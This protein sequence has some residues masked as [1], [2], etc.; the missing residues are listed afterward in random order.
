MV[1]LDRV[2]PKIFKSHFMTE[3]DHQASR[4]VDQVMGAFFLVRRSVFEILGG[5]DERFFV[6]FEEVDLAVRARA[7][8][9]R[10]FYLSEAQAYHKGGG[11]THRIKSTSL[12]Y[13][14]RSRMLY[15][16]KHFG[17]WAGSGVTLGTLLLEPIAR[18][19]LAA[20][21]GP[22]EQFW[23]TLGAYTMLWSAMPRTLMTAWRLRES[24]AA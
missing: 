10:T 6:Y 12:F 16:Y 23:A 22:L 2:L 15:A 21:R 20:S 14:L 19:T 1:G 24:A 11:T 17:W 8:G 18:L 3:W 13:S 5:F 9:W 4:E 7:R